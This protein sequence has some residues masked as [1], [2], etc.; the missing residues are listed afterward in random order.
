MSDALAPAANTR[1][2]SEAG[3]RTSGDDWA[4]CRRVIAEH[5]KSFH[6]A[7][8]LFPRGRR[9]EASA[10][11]A[12]CRVCDDAI[13]LAPRDQHAQA[14]ATLRERLRAVHAG[15]PQ[16]DAVHRC[17]QRVVARRRIPIEYPLELLEGM[18]MD[19]ER[20]HYETVDDLLV[21]CWRVAG[22]VGMMM[23]HVMGVSDPRAGPHAAHLGVAMQLTNISR[24]V[25]EDWER[26][27]LYLPAEW[28]PADLARELRDGL[29][30]PLPA[31]AGAELAA[32]TRRLLELA[33]R[34][35]A[36]ADV[37]LS[38][39]EPRSAL[40]VRTARL[41]YAEIGAEVARRGFDPLL[42]RA[43]VPMRRKL[44]LTGRALLRFLVDRRR[45]GKTELGAPAGVLDAV[46]AVRL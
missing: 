32:A 4:A 26:G 30:G 21:Y 41:V 42:G 40:A 22:V 15:E 27:R 18:A 7:S 46:E 16:P 13:D 11:Y 29:G 28:L 43:V 37:G 39:L 44:R 45:W 17:F 34:Y 9:D 8:R 38:Y 19:V 36:S 20:S 3:A 1:V 14:L 24:D 5:S 2:E 25:L 12:W 6:L 33:D 35:Y 23:C 10:V 31:R